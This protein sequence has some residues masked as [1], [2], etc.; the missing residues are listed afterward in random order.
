MIEDVKKSERE[1]TPRRAG[2]A[3]HF[4]VDAGANREQGFRSP[5]LQDQILGV[6]SALG[7]GGTPSA[8]ILR[9]KAELT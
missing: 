8:V 9:A 1:Q 6:G 2:A 4:F 3:H 5:V 7:A